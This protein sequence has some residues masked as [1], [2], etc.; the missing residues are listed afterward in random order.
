MMLYIE[1]GHLEYCHNTSMVNKETCYHECFSVDF[2]L[3]HYPINDP[4]NYLNKFLSTYITS[5]S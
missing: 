2:L 1:I 3:K 5:F 4:Q